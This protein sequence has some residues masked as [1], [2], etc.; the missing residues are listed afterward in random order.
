LAEDGRVEDASARRPKSCTDE[1]CKGCYMTFP[2]EYKYCP[3]CGKKL[4]KIE[5]ET[6]SQNIK[7]ENKQNQTKPKIKVRLYCP[8]C[9]YITDHKIERR[10][11]PK[12]N[13]PLRKAYYV[14]K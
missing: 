9:G 7:Q 5:H 12:C 13:N 2:D 1:N 4:E 14:E 11:C 6:Y 10:F 8:A 3:Y